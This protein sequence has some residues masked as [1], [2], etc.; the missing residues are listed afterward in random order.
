MGKDLIYRIMTRLGF[1]WID[2]GSK[3]DY[4]AGIGST[5]RYG[6]RKFNPKTMIKSSGGRFTFWR[7]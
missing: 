6:W 1:V 2:K 4:I 3:N 7:R 5:R